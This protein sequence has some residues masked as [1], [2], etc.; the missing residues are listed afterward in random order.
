VEKSCSL[1]RLIA[2]EKRFQKFANPRRVVF[3]DCLGQALAIHLPGARKGPLANGAL[4]FRQPVQ[5][6]QQVDEQELLADAWK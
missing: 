6:V 4:I 2:L 3:V 5:V 1:S